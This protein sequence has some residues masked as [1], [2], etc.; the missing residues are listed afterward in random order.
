MAR[1]KKA[2][3]RREPASFAHTLDEIE[4]SGDRLTQWALDNPRVV[5]VL[6]AAVAVAAAVYGAVRSFS[7]S[8][9][10]DA[11][12]AL[13]VV[14]TDYRRAMG[15]TA[16]DVTVP[17]PANPETGRKVREEYIGRFQKVADDYRG[18][19]AGAIASLDE[20]GIQEELG[21]REEALSTWREAAASLG[22]DDA[23][24]ALLQLRIAAVL[25]DEE[26]WSEAAEAYERAADVQ[27]FPLRETARAEAARCY[28][29]AGDNE[30]AL[31][32]FERVKLEDPDAYLP[33]YL[34]ARF[35]ELQAAQQQQQ[36]LN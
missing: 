14:Q 21:Q 7:E 24:A 4:S 25:E 3:P 6:L 18:T 26:R 11:S 30:R 35:L 17:E 23:V 1:P 9:A 27:S 32:A 29:E 19:A 33:E 8:S 31:A 22:S 16:D 10:E 13:G 28:A 5:I 36:Q 34:E 12:A 20:G 15:A 2:K